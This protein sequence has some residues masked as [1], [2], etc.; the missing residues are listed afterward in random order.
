MHSCSRSYPADLRYLKVHIAFGT[1][2]H[3]FAFS[4]VG[5]PA[6]IP[7]SSLS[8]PQATHRRMTYLTDTALHWPGD[9]E[10]HRDQTEFRIFC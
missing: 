4:T 7:M 1:F 9:V 6:R 3:I 10:F 2:G 8:K 5:S